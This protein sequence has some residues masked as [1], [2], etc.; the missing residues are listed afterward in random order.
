MPQTL[1]RSAP[2]FLSVLA[3]IAFASSACGEDR[4]KAQRSNTA[5]TGVDASSDVRTE[6]GSDAEAQLDTAL[7]A[8]PAPD[9]SNPNDA[10]GDV[11][12]DIIDDSTDGGGEAQD[13]S[14]G[15]GICPDGCYATTDDDCALDCRDPDT[16]PPSWVAFE[17][18]AIRIANQRRA[19]G[20]N[21]GDEYNPPA[22]P[23]TFNPQ[24]REA[25]RCHSLDMALNDVY[26]HEGSNGSTAGERL[27]A[28]GYDWRTRNEIVAA[29]RFTAAQVVSDW[30]D[31]PG[32]CKGITE[33][34]YHEIGMGYV[35][36]D[37]DA[38]GYNAYWT[39]V[40]AT[41]W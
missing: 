1:R 3:C 19:Q 21:C 28:T 32:H 23:M 15:D 37:P 11:G 16:W 12:S 33:A 31:S 30:M 36:E 18:E 4:D 27:D 34:K 2:H 13:C 40:V 9:T 35:F 6:T 20:A 38:L 7:D 10:S 8:E 17:D 29:K 24:L 5:E 14:D 26:G 22:D 41:S 25:A 39:G